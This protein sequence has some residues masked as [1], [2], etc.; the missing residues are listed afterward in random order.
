[1]VP[2]I[3]PNKGKE[4]VSQARIPA[5]T[6]KH[7]DLCKMT[8]VSEL[9]DYL[10]QFAADCRV[11]KLSMQDAWLRLDAAASPSTRT[12]LQ[13]IH[14][15]EVHALHSFKELFNLLVRHRWLADLDHA[16]MREVEAFRRRD[17]EPLQSFNIRFLDML[18]TAGLANND[19]FCRH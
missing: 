1:M 8:L 7:F 5:V 16:R 13:S 19:T 10:S 14:P 15:E 11:G 18:N 9:Q 12:I 3:S 17:G 6:A 4:E 2:P